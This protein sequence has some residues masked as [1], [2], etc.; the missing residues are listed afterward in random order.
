MGIYSSKNIDD[1]NVTE[2]L[3]LDCSEEEL[4]EATIEAMIA[5]DLAKMTK[6]QLEMFLNSEELKALDE[7]SS[8][9]VGNIGKKTIVRLDKN[10]DM[11][12]RIG[13]AA[14]NIAK[15]NRDPLWIQLAKNRQKEKKLLN[16][17]NKKYEMKATKV[18][19][20]AQKSYMKTHRLAIGF[21]RK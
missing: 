11:E 9:L 2:G 15:E 18:A 5:D 14:L 8:S 16:Q 4:V 20:K 3:D 12:R 6:A 17:I 13:M 1:V 10:D 21:L 19:K 7:E